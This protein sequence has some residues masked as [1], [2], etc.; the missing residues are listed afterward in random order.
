MCCAEDT[1]KAQFLN[2][3]NPHFHVQPE[4]RGKF[5]VY[6]CS[7][8]ID[9]LIYPKFKLREIGFP[10]EW[11]G[12][13]VKHIDDNNFPKLIQL[14]WQAITYQQ[15]I[16]QG[17]TRKIRPIFTLIHTNHLS[18]QLQDYILPLL[19]LAQYANVGLYE[20][21]PKGWRIKFS[22]SYITYFKH[23]GKFRINPTPNLGTVIYAGNSSQKRGLTTEKNR[24]IP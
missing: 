4:V 21:T 7:V 23:S 1:L 16:Y 5:L 18:P 17:N 22:S 11:V 20:F 15:S 12:V 3:I 14:F 2:T 8:C 19:I 13:E 9:F 6:D 24:I 10:P